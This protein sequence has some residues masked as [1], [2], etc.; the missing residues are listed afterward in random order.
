[1]TR[2]LQSHIDQIEQDL[3]DAP[4]H[5]TGNGK[6]LRDM[7]DGR[8]TVWSAQMDAHGLSVTVG[9]DCLGVRLSTCNKREIK[10][11]VAS[12]V[13]VASLFNEPKEL[14]A[15]PYEKTK[16][17][18]KYLK[19]EP[20]PRL[21][22]FLDEILSSWRDLK[23]VRKEKAE[24]IARKTLRTC[25]N[26]GMSLQELSW[27]WDELEV[28]K[29]HSSRL[30][31]SPSDEISSTCSDISFP[32][33]SACLRMAFAIASTALL[34]AFMDAFDSSGG[35]SDFDASGNLSMARPR[36]WN[37]ISSFFSSNFSTHSWYPFHRPFS[38]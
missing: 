16:R 13:T 33:W 32:S 1:M 36:K 17:L 15:N 12:I 19:C 14:F 28:E 26:A 3:L 8:F 30:A 9:Q 20:G 2:T 34:R 27:I 18:S 11:L 5:K 22:S 29:I 10:R 24:K 37:R 4:S 21:R 6:W 31:R 25:R 7:R 38:G 35:V 23:D